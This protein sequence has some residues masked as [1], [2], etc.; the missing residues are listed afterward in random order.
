MDDSPASNC[1]WYFVEEGEGELHYRGPPASLAGQTVVH[2]Q[3]AVS[4]SLQKGAWPQVCEL[5]DPLEGEHKV[6]F[7]TGATPAQD[8]TPCSCR[9]NA[10][11][12]EFVSDKCKI[13]AADAWTPVNSVMSVPAVMIPFGCSCELGAGATGETFCYDML[14]LPSGG[15]ATTVNVAGCDVPVWDLC[16]AAAPSPTFEGGQYEFWEERPTW[17]GCGASTLSESTANTVLIV[18]IAVV[19]VLAVVALK[20]VFGDKKRPAA[21]SA[22]GSDLGGNKVQPTLSASQLSTQRH[23]A[24]ERELQKSLLQMQQRQTENM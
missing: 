2:H 8:G 6:A 24:V 19:V 18:A 20:M 10:D 11:P 13:C 5:Y 3:Q 4:M 22:T 1:P 23:A 9:N 14:D 12:D 15:D 7:Y 21:L 16:R 17:A